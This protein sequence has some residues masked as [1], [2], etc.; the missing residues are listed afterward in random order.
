MNAACNLNVLRVLVVGDTGVG[1]TLLLRRL[2]QAVAPGE[3]S[4]DTTW[5]PTTG[6]HVEVILEKN[7]QFSLRDSIAVPCVAF[8]ELG[9]NRNFGPSSQFPISLMSFD[10][11]IFVYDR[12]NANSAIGLSYWYE[13]LKNYGVV[14]IVGGAKVML[15]ETALSPSVSNSPNA[16]SGLPDELLGA[17][18]QRN[19]KKPP[20]WKRRFNKIKSSIAQ[21]VGSSRLSVRDFLHHQGSLRVRVAVFILQWALKIENLLLFLV[22]VI[23]F[24]PHQQ[25]VRL[26]RPSVAEALAMISSDVAGTQTVFSCPLFDQLEFEASALGKLLS[27]VD[28]L[29][30]D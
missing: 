21:G 19:I 22:A 5:S 24:G 13:D 4:L 26:R 1:K 6:F 30:R 14:G 20:P 16:N 12:H 11:V 29:R 7:Q 15:L 18:L 23:L 2:L 27:F 28:S 17:Y 8:I 25:S 10:G 9:G 3:A